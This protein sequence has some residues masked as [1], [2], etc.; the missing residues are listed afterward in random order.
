MVG[1]RKK[2]KPAEALQK[3]RAK[4]GKRSQWRITREAFRFTSSIFIANLRLN[5]TLKKIL[6]RKV[7]IGKEV[8]RLQDKLMAELTNERV[9]L[10]PITM[11]E[12]K[13][14]KKL[15]AVLDAIRKNVSKHITYEERFLEAFKKFEEISA[16]LG[17]QI[18]K[19]KLKLHSTVKE[20]LPNNIAKLKVVQEQISRLEALLAKQN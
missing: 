15:H 18:S 3:K 7:E 10:K 4:L 5:R 17:L 14:A 12:V 2:K 6:G 1:K 11:E 8:N 20:S 19:S 9:S 16:D 13:N